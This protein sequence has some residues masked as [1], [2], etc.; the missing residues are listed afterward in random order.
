VATPPDKLRRVLGPLVASPATTA[1]VTDFDGTLAPIVEDPASARPVTG[2]TEV[3]VE[4][5]AHFGVVAV[6]SG[7]PLAY[8]EDQL[9][10]PPPPVPTIRTGGTRGSPGAR[11]PGPRL[12]GLY[13]LERARPDGRIDLDPAVEPWLPV[14]AESVARLSAGAPPGVLVEAKGATVALHWRRA[15]DSAGWVEA[16]VAEETARSSLRAFPGRMSV[17]LRP[18]LEVD[19]GTVVAELVRGSTAACYFGD[20]LGDLPAFAALAAVGRRRGMTALSIAVVDDETPV[21][22][23]DAAD[24]RVLGPRSALDVLRWLAESA[25]SRA[26]P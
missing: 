5:T 19:K 2:A 21:D 1:I 24:A 7:R 9:G 4:L 16:A 15:P 22:V 18:P 3:L 26:S 11:R 25:G 23:A 12:F 20:D 13:G 14:V 8:L 6:V 17:E 10:L